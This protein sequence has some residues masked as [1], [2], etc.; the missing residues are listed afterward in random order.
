[1]PEVPNGQF[2]VKYKQGV[3]PANSHDKVMDFQA[4]NL[5]A[6][7]RVDSSKLSLADAERRAERLSALLR[8]K[9]YGQVGYAIDGDE[10]E[11]M[12]T[13]PQG[14]EL[15]E[16]GKL[17][18]G[19][20]AE[21]LGLPTEDDDLVDM[22]LFIADTDEV[23]DEEYHTYGGKRIFGSNGQCTTGFTV[24]RADGTTGVSTAGHCT[25]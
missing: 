20:A 25:G 5:G 18:P 10:L 23:L 3:I 21:V 17:P 12:A 15:P 7:V 1:M 6:S 22:A 2:V 19:K 14:D 11:L 8:N 16:R 24:R 9:N 4:G 13:V